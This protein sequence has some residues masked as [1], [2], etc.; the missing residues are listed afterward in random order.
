ML[1]LGVEG[2]VPPTSSQ[3]PLV[4]GMHLRWA[5][6]A[7]AGFPWHG[8]YL[9]KRPSRTASL[10]CFAPHWHVL[11]S[12]PPAQ[13]WTSP[14][15]TISSEVPLVPV[16][17]PFMAF[18]PLIELDLRRRKSIRV[19]LPPGDVAHTAHVS[20]RSANESTK[21]RHCVKFPNTATLPNPFV[22]DGIRFSVSSAAGQ[23]PTQAH[24]AL[25]NGLTGLETGAELSIELPAPTDRVSLSIFHADIVPLVRAFDSDGNRLVDQPGKTSWWQIYTMELT[26]PGIAR[27]TIEG[28]DVTY[29]SEVCYGAPDPSTD[30]T[31][32]VRV[33]AFDGK[34]LVDAK[35]IDGSATGELHADRITA[36]EIDG[37]AEASV[38]D[39]CYA[40]SQDDDRLDWRPLTGVNPITLP[41]ENTSGYPATGAPA[42]AA[43]AEAVALG[44]IKYGSASSW[45]GPRFGEIRDQLKALVKNGPAG[46]AMVDRSVELASGPDPAPPDP[47][48]LLLLGALDP[49]VAQMLGLYHVDTTAPVGAPFDYLVV[50]DPDGRFQG[51]EQ[52][53]LGHIAIQGFDQVDAWITYGCVRAPAAH[54]A[55]PENLRA[56]A[57]PAATRKDVQSAQNGAGL[58]WTTPFRSPIVMVH[59][60]RRTYGPS[61]PNAPAP[62]ASF[63][64][65]TNDRPV[66]V[67]RN[68]SSAPTDPKPPSDWPPVAPYAIDA[69]LVD[70]WYGYRVSGI[71]IFGRHSPLSVDAQWWQWSPAPDPRPW[72][73]QGSG[74]DAS[75]HAFAIR[76]LDKLPPPPPTAIEASV[77][78]PADPFLLQDASYAA[79]RSGVSATLVGLRVTW[80]WP[81]THALQAPDASEFRVY[82]NAGSKPPADADVATNW[83]SRI[84]VRKI[85]QHARAITES[86]GTTT[87]IYELFLPAPLADLTP[88]AATPLLYA[89]VSVSTADDKT[90]T[91]D[92]PKWP[93]P[94]GNRHGNEGSVGVPATVYRVLRTP[95]PPPEP[96][97]DADRMTFSPA[98]YHNRSF[99]SYRWPPA[100]HLKL[101]VYRALD[102]SVFVAD[103]A[104]RPR[105]PLSLSDPAFPNTPRWNNATRQQVAVALDALNAFT[106]VSKAMAAYRALPDDALRVLAGFADLADTFQ[107]VTLTPLDPAAPETANRRGP[108]NDD[109]FPVDATLRVYID[110]VNGRGRNRYFYRAAYID[111]AHNRSALSVAD[112]PVYLPVVDPPRTPV[113]TKIVGGDRKITISWASNREPDLAE[114]RVYRS[115]DQDGARDLRLMV[116][117]D[118]IVVTDAERETPPAAVSWSDSSVIGGRPYVYRLTAANE[119]GLVSLPT[120]PLTAAAFDSSPPPP[121]Q[122]V[123]AKWIVLHA[124]GTEAPWPSDGVIPAD[125]QPVV[126][127]MWTSAGAGASF[128]IARRIEGRPAWQPIAGGQKEPAATMF[129]VYDTGANANRAYSYR[130]ISASGAGVTG[131]AVLI[132]VPAIVTGGS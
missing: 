75:L 55:P 120:R 87:R 6:A 21:T 27:V 39:V 64:L 32:S 43:A 70:G 34:T 98:D 118:T 28:N 9:F 47:L 11:S 25:E 94:F 18:P 4:S 84:S 49:A 17:G 97:T 2:D 45:S 89:Q 111:G 56:H 22:R 107:A 57:L 114:Y 20:I 1:A 29:L 124:D 106:D 72:Y 50:A 24:V 13:Q 16:P 58:R 121:P 63:S 130:V 117:V 67:T 78:D 15:G 10:R 123:D 19:E 109:A 125:A 30:A 104:K 42:N 44:R 90:H 52:H 79:W 37:G 77:L 116:T 76:L 122:W 101:N 80:R 119:S 86:D 41:I 59:L 92:A 74:G 129:S 12:L 110:T 31:T 82:L 112:P 85:A 81:E 126:L 113:I 91:A 5:F 60:W 7:D 99:Y 105:A 108:D 61:A 68:A 128:R 127:L 14:L 95:P 73:Y 132:E 103:W 53:V 62:A 35:S 8:F 48:D 40:S 26:A 66:L 38:V 3:P 36:I 115:D 71:D 46:G 51:N 65:V 54:L 33:R 131:D 69:G 83:S 100:P 102:E 88:T 93:P 23:R 96:A